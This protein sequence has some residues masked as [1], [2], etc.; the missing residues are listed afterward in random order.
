MN[1]D[2]PFHLQEVIF[3]SSEPGISR[4]IGQLVKEE[5]LR[6][7]LPR[8]YTPNF[9][10]TPEVLVRRNLFTI[11]GHLFPGIVL[12]HRSALEFKPTSTGD[13]FLTYGYKRKIELPG[14]TLNIME[15][16]AN[17]DGD[18]PLTSGLYV[19]QQARALL[20]N[21]Q[22]SRKPGPKS[23]TLTIP[24]L[25][26]RL[27]QIARIKG[28]EGLNELRDRA[29][30]IAVRLGMNKEF[31]KMNKFISALLA[32]GPTNLLS[33]P[34]AIARTFGH[35]F[36]PARVS[37]FEELFIDLQRQEF[38][39]L[40]EPNTSTFAF[41]NFAFFEAYFSNYIE[42]TEFEIDEA[43]KIIQTGTPLPSRDDD[44]H[45]ILGTYRLLS[46][47]EEMSVTPQSPE[48]MMHI[49]QYRHKILL[50]ARVSKKPGQ[51]KDK[52]NRAGDTFFVDQHL[53]RGTLIKGFDFYRNLKDPFAKAAYMMFLISE[54]HP[55][56]DGNGRIARVM[57]NAELVKAKQTRIIIPTVYREDYMGALRKLT[58]QQSPSAY[59]RMLSRAQQFSAT[60]NGVNMDEMQF[61]LERADAFL[62]PEA[63]KLKFNPVQQSGWPERNKPEEGQTRGP[64]R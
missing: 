59:I 39:S 40:P 17:I 15:G 23:K 6:K 10:E 3:S 12:S 63:G 62:E 50:S 22:E 41:R 26:E 46:N 55:F 58:R 47:Q 36:D 8:V 19:S 2:L 49:L 48:E 33:S 42:G 20:E 25:E 4:K 13:I 21:F 51:F 27:E 64:K 28:E 32:T 37:L 1:M 11:I 52:N 44:S 60:I 16:P 43:K 29:R 9:H 5:K 34:I 7:L 54:V 31:S 30:E 24:E 53:V 61:Q 35:P 56:L 57:M 14:V 38:P 18:N 45:D